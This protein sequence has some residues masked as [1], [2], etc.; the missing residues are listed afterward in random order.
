MVG[1][2]A[3]QQRALKCIFKYNYKYLTPYR[4]SLDPINVVFQSLKLN[5][6]SYLTKQQK[7]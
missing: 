6:M 2:E 1:D 4:F 7:F 3:V 5:A